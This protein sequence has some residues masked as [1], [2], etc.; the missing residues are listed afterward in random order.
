MRER[1]KGIDKAKTSLVAFINGHTILSD[2]WK[3]EVDKFFKE[4]PE[5]DIVGGPQHNWFR[6]NM[7]ARET[8]YA[9]S[10][11]FGAGGASSRYGGENLIM[12]AD[13]THLTSANMICRKKVFDKVMFDENL[14]PGEDPKFISDAKKAGFRVAYSPDIIVYNKR[15]ETPSSL[16]RQIFDYGRMR[17]RKEGLVE[18]ITKHPSF[19]IPSLFVLYLIFLP[20]FLLINILFLHNEYAI[21]ILSPLILYAILNLFFSFVNP[22]LFAIFPMIHVS[23][24]LGFLYGTIGGM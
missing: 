4:H 14:Y 19:I 24:G 22:L 10:T 11:R 8:G 5:I 21:L 15:R 3:E 6:D 1:N 23:Y 16:I 20:L 9:L 2:N 13:E 17:P 12:N 18:T 7:F